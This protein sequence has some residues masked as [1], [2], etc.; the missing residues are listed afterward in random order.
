MVCNKHRS[1]LVVLTLILSLALAMSVVGASAQTRTGA[2]VDEVVASEEPAAAA[3]VSRLEAN[4]I[5]LYSFTVS[6]PEIF[7]RILA[8]DSLGYEQAFGSYSELTFNPAGPVFSGSGK[9]NPFAVPEIREAVNWLIDRE[10][11]AEEIYGGMAVPRYLP[12]HGAFPDYARLVDVARTFELEY[13]SDPARAE[14]VI[15][16]EM[17]S[18]GAERVNGKWHYQGEPVELIFIIRTEDERREIGDYLATLF[19]NLGFAVDR[20]YKNAAE[21]SPIW[22][23]GDPNAGEFHVYTGG[24]ITTAISRDEGGNFDFFFTNRGLAFPLWQNYAPTSE[25]DAL[26]DRLNRNDFQSVEERKEL[27]TQALEAAMKD[28]VHIYLV[29]RFGVIPRSA[30]L[31]VSADLAGGISGTL[32]WPHT[33]RRGDEVGGTLNVALPSILPEPWNPL[34]GSNWIYDQM[35]I[36]GTAD[37]G[38]IADPFT[39]LPRPQRIERAEIYIKE[40]LPVGQT[41]DWVDLSFVS[42]IEV[43]SDAWVDWDAEKQRFITA[44]ELYPQGRTAL[45]KSVVYYPEDIYEHQ[46][47]D[48]SNLSAADFVMGMILTF[49]RAKEASANYDETKVSLLDSLL[50]SFKGVR[51]VSTDPLVIETYNDQYALDAEMN[52]D[53]WFPIYTQG[54]GPWHTLALGLKAEAA[55]EVA[56]SSSKAGKLEAEWMSYIAGPSIAVLGKHLEQIKAESF[57]PYAPTLR[58]YATALEIAERWQNLSDWYSARGH[59]WVGSGPLMLE[60]AYPVESVAHLKRFA[61]YRDPSTK[62]ARFQEPLIAEVELDGARR[63]R[64]GETATFDV[65]VTFKDEPYLIQNMDT[66]TYLLFDANGN[67]ALS[68]DAE[69]VADGSW[70]VTLSSDQTKSLPTGSNRLEVIVAPLVVSIPSFASYQFVSTP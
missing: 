35:L 32:L 4:E 49:D 22:I 39:G 47:H 68:G 2:W 56:F 51:I 65:T 16:A 46:W 57:V 17:E 59:F 38:V 52:A 31:S 25:F 27:F 34:D 41:L 50:R 36:R 21:A 26:A 15:S 69:A 61:D 9:L 55:G 18:L 42:E 14:S 1:A 64:S 3:A 5:D 66:V 11:I 58:Q 24:W 23:Q 53:T 43:P 54:P 13:A 60:R 45:R 62:W 8:N 19:E 7:E 67:L 29:D 28:S 33:I 20:Q 12:I 44:E 10:Y 6:D 63:V 37:D 48:G 40:G 30:D 70:R